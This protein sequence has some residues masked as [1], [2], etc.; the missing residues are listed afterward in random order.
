MGFAFIMF[1]HWIADFIFQTEWMANKKHEEWI[2]LLV[3]SA[4]Y[5][6]TVTLVLWLTLLHVTI[7]EAKVAFIMLFVS[8]AAID[9]ITSRINY[10]L[11]QD[12][13]VRQF[14]CCIGLDQWMHLTILLGLYN[15]LGG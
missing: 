7:M 8:H 10:M 11:W 12:G 2:P 15:V 13:L 9:W 14:F 5:A 1:G 3:H 4:V 6:L